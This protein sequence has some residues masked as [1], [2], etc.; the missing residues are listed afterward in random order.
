M[1]I[2]QVGSATTASKSMSYDNLVTASR[3][4]G[5]GSNR[6]LVAVVLSVNG[7]DVYTVTFDE[8]GA[9][10]TA[11]TKLG[12]QAIVGGSG[13]WYAKNAPSGASGTFTVEA[14]SREWRGH[15]V[16]TEWTGVDDVDGFATANSESTGPTVNITTTS[17]SVV[18]DG[19]VA[20]AS[21]TI[22]ASQTELYNGVAETLYGSSSK[23]TAT[24]AS[25]TMSWTLSP[26]AYWAIVGASI[27][28]AGGASSTPSL[29]MNLGLFMGM[30]RG[31]RGSAK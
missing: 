17:G 24:G 29:G 9:N 1:A 6:M 31:M 21:P 3:T 7:T 5:T 20:L 23:E 27:N 22:G 11:L 15:V 14:P 8:G 13:I 28:E 30:F 18:I 26:A 4:L 25:V 2:A 16:V 12:W 19:L 10:E